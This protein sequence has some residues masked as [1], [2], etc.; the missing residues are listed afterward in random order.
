VSSKVES[1]DLDKGLLFIGL[2][3]YR[4]A[5]G[6]GPFSYA[7]SCPSDS[8]A[9]YLNNYQLS[10]K[11]PWLIPEKFVVLTQDQFATAIENSNKERRL[12]AYWHEP[13]LND[14]AARFAVI[15]RHIFEGQPDATYL[16]GGKWYKAVPAVTAAAPIESSDEGRAIFCTAAARAAAIQGKLTIYGGW[17]LEQFRAEELGNSDGF[18]GLTPEILFKIDSQRQLRTAALAGTAVNEEQRKN[19]LNDPKERYEHDLVVDAIAERLG[20][21][22]PVGVTPPK[23]MELKTLAHLVT[24]ITLTFDESVEVTKLIEALHPTPAVGGIPRKETTDWILK[25]EEQEPR[26]NF[27]APFGLHQPGVETR[28]VICIRGAFFHPRRIRVPSGC[29]IVA[30]SEEQREW[31]ELAAKRAMVLDMLF[32]A[33]SVV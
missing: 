20:A 8:V 13:D 31:R 11:S 30:Q 16:R 12:P 18:L 6:I 32:G 28:V 7:S 15:K 10:L 29:G 4:V 17:G 23:V 26:Y 22:G 19:L 14:F 5:V 2:P 25:S 33:V 3:D 27:S 21:Y 24:E 1:F 9:F